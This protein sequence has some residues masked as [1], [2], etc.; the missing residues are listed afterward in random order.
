M[1]AAA[2]G[3]PSGVS[4]NLPRTTDMTVAAT[5]M[6]TVPATAGVIILRSRESREM[7]ANWTRAETAMRL[8]SIAGPPARRAVM[9]TA[10]NGVAVITL[11]AYPDPNRQTRTVWRMAPNPQTA[12][13]VKNI[14]DR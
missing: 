3:V 10:I 6:R 2:C 13:A 8:D 5:S 4:G 7:S 9:Q 1:G 11:S 14:H 12:S